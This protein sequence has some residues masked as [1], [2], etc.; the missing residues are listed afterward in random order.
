MLKS[1]DL[2][3][4]FGSV[5]LDT[6]IGKNGSKLSGGQ[7]QLVW[8]MRV[9]LYDPDILILDEPTASIDE[10][11]KS[12]LQNMLDIIMKN[13]TVIMVTHDPFLVGIATR[14]VTIDHGQIKSDVTTTQR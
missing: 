10:K 9:L 6:R 2:E 7:R 8:C 1:F 14:I 12:I 4:E 11:T 5:G 3:T 13:K